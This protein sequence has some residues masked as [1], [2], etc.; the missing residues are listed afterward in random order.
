MSDIK[1]EL[2]QKNK[3]WIPKHRYYELKHYCLQYPEWKRQYFLEK[4]KMEVGA[5]IIVPNKQKN[6]VRPVEK[7]GITLGEL[8]EKLSKIEETCK[9]A[10]KDIWPWLLRAVTDG[11]SFTR[12]KTL[13]DIPCER[14]M[15]YDRYRKFFWLL[16][17]S[18]I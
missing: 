8:S 12:L 7:A 2:S 13:Y 9:L 4:F 11:V 6:L 15:F 10:D 16:D 5:D 17:K 14:D 18:H 3:Y 1:P